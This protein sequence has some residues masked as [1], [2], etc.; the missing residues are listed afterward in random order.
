MPPSLRELGLD[1]LS[2][3][4]RLA[5]AEAIWDSVARDVD[6]ESLTPGQEAELRRR[7]DD[8]IARPDTVI[9]WEVVK[10][11]AMGRAR[12]NCLCVGCR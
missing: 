3:E 4:D 11:E 2:T 9:P 8:S 5:L 10:A 7:L 12:N 1:Q 6:A